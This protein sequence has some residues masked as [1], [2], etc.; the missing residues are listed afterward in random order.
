MMPIKL[1]IKNFLCYG[2]DVA[3]LDFQEIELACLS[4]ENGHGKTAILDAITWCLWGEAREIRKGRDKTLQD[5][6]V[7]VG[8]KTAWV[9]LD[10]ESQGQVY[11]FSKTKTV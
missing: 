5:E 9:K 2:E 1:Q 3:T 11:R 10:F 8:Q 6:F 4:G 7:R